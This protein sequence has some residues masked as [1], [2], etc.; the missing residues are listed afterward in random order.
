MPNPSPLPV[1]QQAITNTSTQSFLGLDRTHLGRLQEKLNAHDWLRLLVLSELHLCTVS[2]LTLQRCNLQPDMAS[3]HYQYQRYALW[4]DEFEPGKKQYEIP[5]LDLTVSASADSLLFKQRH[6]ENVAQ[7][8]PPAPKSSRFVLF[9]QTRCSFISNEVRS[10][11][12]HL[13]KQQS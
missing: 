11:V 13:E 6:K 10:S 9:P 8:L 2:P 3:L 5:L 7:L 4:I 12:N 1:F